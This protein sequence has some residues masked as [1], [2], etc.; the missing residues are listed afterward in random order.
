LAVALTKIVP[1]FVPV[2]GKPSYQ[3]GF[4]RAPEVNRSIADKASAA[5]TAFFIV[6]LPVV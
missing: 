4:A 6:D 1:A 5:V 2:F 3:S